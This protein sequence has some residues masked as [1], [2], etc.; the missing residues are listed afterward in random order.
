MESQNKQKNQKRNQKQQ[1]K[2]H[3]L[4]EHLSGV[5][6]PEQ[7]IVLAL[8]AQ[9]KH[10]SGV[11][12]QKWATNGRWTPKMG[13]NLALNAQSCVQGHFT[14]LIWCKVVNPWTPQD[15]WTPQDH[16]RICGPHRIPTYFHSLLLTLSLS[17]HG[18]PFCFPFNTHIHTHIPPS[19]PY[20]LPLLLF[21]LLLLEGEQHSKFGVV[22]A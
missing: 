18:H 5:Q 16:L 14:C 12:R 20:L 7:S 2:N 9:N 17:I 11:Q 22:K 21:F 19:P 3:T 4:E 10:G 15:L 8:N 6:T 13:T 1:K